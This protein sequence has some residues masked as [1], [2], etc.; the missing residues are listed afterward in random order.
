M[1]EIMFNYSEKT[2]VDIKFKMLDL[3][4]TIKAD[5]SVKTD[6]GIIVSVILSN[7]LSPEKTNMEASENVKEIYVIDIILNSKRV[8]EIF[9]DAF[10]RFIEFQTLFR[11]HFQDEIKYLV[12]IKTF[13]DEKMKILKTFESNWKKE[14]KFDFPFTTKLEKVFKE[15]LKYVVGYAFRQDESFENYVKRLDEIKKL[16]SEIDKQT[17]LMAAEKQPNIKMALNDKIKEMKRNLQELE[18]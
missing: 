5:K 10:N 7:T 16:K 14:E 6:A 9:V 17:R 4:K 2:K 8:P 3:F 1:S 15:M 12:A 18:K 11:L 13:S